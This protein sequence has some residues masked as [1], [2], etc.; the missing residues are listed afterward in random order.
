MKSVKIATMG[1]CMLA[2]CSCS[3]KK[4]TGAL[5]GTGA[6]TVVGG[7]I[8]K[9]A[10]NTAVGAAIGGAVG[11]GAGAIIGNHMDKVAAETAAQVENAKVEEV[12]D[13]N[14]LKAVKVTFDSGILF[15][16]NQSTLNT[17]SKNELARFSNVLKNNADCHVDIYGYTDRSG[18]DAINIPLSQKRAQSVANY[19]SS[20]GVSGSQMQNIVGKGSQ[21]E[22]EDKRV[23]QI[24]RRVE[25][26]LY[27]SPAMVEAA[28]AGTLN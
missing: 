25:V 22:I 15:R 24:N 26:Y 13:A 23:S 7:I 8:G 11:A 5:I 4:G 3:T 12:T 10:G 19:L 21:D 18:N 27:A 1:L 2:V 6:G 9:I 16:T 20:C 28:N 14:G 17:T